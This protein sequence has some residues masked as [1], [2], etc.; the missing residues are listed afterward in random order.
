MAVPRN[1]ALV[2]FPVRCRVLGTTAMLVAS[3]LALTNGCGGTVSL[4]ED[5]RHGGGLDGGLYAPQG[6]ATGIIARTDPGRPPQGRCGNGILEGSESCDMS[7]LGGQT[8]ATISMGRSSGFLR[9]TTGCTFDTSSCVAQPGPPPFG[10]GGA[11]YGSGGFSNGGGGRASGGYPTTDAARPGPILC[12]PGTVADPSSESSCLLGGGTIDACYTWAHAKLPKA[13]YT[14]SWCG[15]GCGCI[16]CATEFSNCL[17]DPGCAAILRCVD[18]VGCTQKASCSGTCAGTIAANGGRF[19]PSDQRADTYDT[20]MRKV[21]CT[22]PCNVE[23][24]LAL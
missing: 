19:G 15:A 10:A 9:C 16:S 22:M 2:G 8:C 5:R 24:G 11:P 1:G 7:N 20:C 21:G 6:G 3:A 12:P 18:A 13:A 14:Y 4:G 23:G 17:V